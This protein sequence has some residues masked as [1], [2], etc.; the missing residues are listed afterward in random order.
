[1][2]SS[3]PSA[4]TCMTRGWPDENRR[5]RSPGTRR[6]HSTRMSGL[7]TGL[8][9]TVYTYTSSLRPRRLVPHMGC[10]LA[11]DASAWRARATQRQRNKR[12]RSFPIIATSGTRLTSE[13]RLPR[14]R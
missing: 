11:E 2:S 4:P 9:R 12:A 3:L 5:R 10:V 6:D 14:R 7:P 13:S 1:M 8:S